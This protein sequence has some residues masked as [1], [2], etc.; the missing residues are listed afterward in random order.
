M[1]R[2]EGALSGGGRWI[3]LS[4]QACT[5]VSNSVNEA[6]KSLGLPLASQHFGLS[7][8]SRTSEG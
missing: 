3:D 8:S 1:E 5:G 6:L 4:D 2:R 7:R